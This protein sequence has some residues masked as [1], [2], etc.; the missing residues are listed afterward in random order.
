M[1]KLSNI[2]HHELED[3]S[4]LMRNVPSTVM[5]FFCVSVVL[6]NLLANKE[7]MNIGW[8][9][10]DCGFAVSWLS[11]LA[12]DMLTRRFGPK[13]AIKLSAFAILVNF[14]FSILLYIISL[15]PGNWGEYYSYESKIVNTVLDNTVGGTWYIVIGSM[16]AFAA[17]SVVNAVINWNVGKLCKSSSY[18][19]FA[20]RSFISTA[21]GQFVDNFVFA[22]VISR[23]FFGW[24]LFQVITCSFTGAVAELLAEVIFSP[25]GFKATQRWE[26]LN[27]GKEYLEY[28]RRSNDR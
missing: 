16:T 14:V 27:I 19:A 22:F 11:F 2:L 15:V 5:V 13:A 10:L 23:T 26:S 12:M 4:I 21:L 7:L 17:G 6:M 25:I 3:T 18:V 1:K 24:T 8:L 20:I 9:A 28:R